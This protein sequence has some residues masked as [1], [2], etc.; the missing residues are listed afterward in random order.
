MCDAFRKGTIHTV[1]ITPARFFLSC[2][3]LLYLIDLMANYGVGGAG[4]FIADQFN[5]FAWPG[6]MHHSELN[7][8][9]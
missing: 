8:R 5:I 4:V 3:V 7:F 2:Y 6:N 1:V 9:D